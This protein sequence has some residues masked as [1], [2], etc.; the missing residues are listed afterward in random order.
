MNVDGLSTR[1]RPETVVDLIGSY[2]SV[3]YERRTAEKRPKLHRLVLRESSHRS[4]MPFRLHDQCAQT[5]RPGAVFN[6]PRSSPEDL[7]AR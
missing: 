5:Q 2:E 4:D 3:C 6:Q 7:A 1:M